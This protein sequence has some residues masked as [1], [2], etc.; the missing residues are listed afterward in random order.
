MPYITHRSKFRAHL[1]RISGARVVLVRPHYQRVHYFVRFAEEHR[2]KRPGRP[3]VNVTEI[4]DK[5]GN[6]LE[7]LRLR[8]EK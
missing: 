6:D 3:V 5:R 8:R 4:M 7:D 2:K 1:R